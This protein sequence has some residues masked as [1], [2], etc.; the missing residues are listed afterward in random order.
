MRCRHHIETGDN[1]H[2]RCLCVTSRSRPGGNVIALGRRRDRVKS[3]LRSA[4]STWIDQRTEFD[5]VR[6]RLQERADLPAWP[7]AGGVFVFWLLLP[8]AV[9]WSWPE[10]RSAPLWGRTIVSKVKMCQNP[11]RQPG[12]QARRPRLQIEERSERIDPPFA[13]AF[14]AVGWQKLP[15]VGVRYINRTPG[16][17]GDINPRTFLRSSSPLCSNMPPTSGGKNSPEVGA[18]HE[19]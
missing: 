16:V 3:H 12:Q 1:F 17:F 6:D 7:L 14:R 9:V 11:N 19:R 2:P 8:F 10:K 5:R 18:R 13:L 15:W 4:L